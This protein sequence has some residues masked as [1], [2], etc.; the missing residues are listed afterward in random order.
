[1]MLQKILEKKG[2]IITLAVAFTI[3]MSAAI[4]KTMP[5]I[6][7]NLSSDIQPNFTWSNDPIL[8]DG[9]V[10]LAEFANNSGGG[11]GTEESPFLLEYI[12]IDYDPESSPSAVN[13]MEI[14]NT[15]LTFR[16]Q[17]SVFRVHW[18]NWG[19]FNTGSGVVFS[20]VI[21]GTMDNVT[22]LYMPMSGISIKSGCENIH[23]N[24]SVFEGDYFW[25]AI[26]I[27]GSN[28]VGLYNNTITC[29]TKDS[30]GGL[31][32]D[33]M[34]SPPD[35]ITMRN[36]AFVNCSI[37]ILAYDDNMLDHDIDESN[38]VNGDPIF[39]RTSD[40]D[41]VIEDVPA[42][43][44]LLLECTNYT[45]DNVTMAGV[46]S[47]YSVGG[48]GVGFAYCSD[49]LVNDS[50]IA[51]FNTGLAALASSDVTVQGCTFEGGDVLL[52]LYYSFYCLVDS[53]VFMNSSPD[54]SNA[55]G[56]VVVEAS[57]YNDITGNV[58]DSSGRAGICIKS[59][60][61]SNNVL[62]NEIL[63]GEETGLFI[64]GD[65]N[66]VKYNTIA[67]NVK[68]GVQLS[69]DANDNSIWLNVFLG[70]A[71]NGTLYSAQAYDDGSNN[72]WSD[73][74]GNY[75]ADYHE[76]YP[77]AIKVDWIWDTPYEI[78]G[79]ASTSDDASLGRTFDHF[80]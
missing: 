78:D 63:D 20:S 35:N 56:T 79:S 37:V 77:D 69:S 25:D 10:E 34:N 73:Q 6:Q 75:W 51:P 71:W 70:N 50:L 80:I 67:G 44:V 28:N 45:I 19:I 2:T 48:L 49:I 23:I 1:M 61:N 3:V 11:D 5:E 4:L 36:N 27:S 38:T 52:T 9:N 53:N 76:R 17:H 65:S 57:S 12:Y 40:S 62:S 55:T 24:N 60:S 58:I 18:G 15:N 32:I 42:G 31:Y 74:F 41:G 43:E 72:L 8:I 7:T 39:Y 59:G 16:L 33:N 30:L 22:V 26:D 14:R 29:T 47:E 21:N 46:G 66:T 13:N 64:G 54:S 68:Y